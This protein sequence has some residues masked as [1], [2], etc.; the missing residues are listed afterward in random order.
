MGSLHLDSVNNRFEIEGKSG[1]VYSLFSTD[2]FTQDIQHTLTIDLIGDSIKVKIEH[3]MFV[4][5]VGLRNPTSETL[6]LKK[7]Y[8]VNLESDD[9]DFY[10]NSFFNLHE[11]MISKLNDFEKY[12]TSI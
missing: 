11:K 9:K 2:L 3:K 8:P 4:K 12:I 7:L 10:G 6:E 1:I 5:R